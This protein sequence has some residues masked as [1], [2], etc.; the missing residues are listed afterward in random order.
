MTYRTIGVLGG[1]GPAAGLHFAR[2][3]I[4][5]N[6]S[7]NHDAGHVPFILS[8]NPLL[9]S[10]VDAYLHGG[11]N[12]ASA[13][14]ASLQVLHEQGADVG[15]IVCNTAH[16]YFDD[17]ARHTTLPLINMV[18]NAISH[19]CENGN[20]RGAVGLLGTTA[21]VKSQLY[22]AAL[23]AR[24][25]RVIVP[26]D[27]DQEALSAA[28]FD[29]EYGIKAT[30]NSPSER[31]YRTMATVAKKMKEKSGID[32]LLLGCTELSL[33]IRADTWEGLD[34]IDPVKILA[35][36]CLRYAGIAATHERAAATQAA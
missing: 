18:Q 12:P 36:T 28:I 9:P 34:I 35:R 25:V 32:Q 5:L 15:V 19:V 22:A 3:L 23:E 16:I 17:I 10:R 8:S 7:A 31:A 1:M 6:S 27:A 26:N 2:L 11:R 21:T 20:E 29:S 14:A 13:I 24:G 4:D 30:R 33:A